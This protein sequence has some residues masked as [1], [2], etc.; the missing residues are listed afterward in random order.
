MSKCQ[1]TWIKIEVMPTNMDKNVIMQTNMDKQ[2]SYVVMSTNMDKK[3]SNVNRH[4]QKCN[5]ANKH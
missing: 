4:G 1:Q 3:Y 2:Y 5:N